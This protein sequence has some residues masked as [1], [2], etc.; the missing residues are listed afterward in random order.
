LE[1]TLRKRLHAS[2]DSVKTLHKV[3]DKTLAG[4]EQAAR[5][6]RAKQEARLAQVGLVGQRLG[7]HI[8][9]EGGVDVQLGEELSESLRGLQ[10]CAFFA[11]QFLVF[12]DAKGE[13]PRSI[14]AIATPDSP[15]EICSEIGF[16]ACN[17]A[18]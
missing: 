15:K 1:R 18:H 8:V 13:P 14:V 11:C 17:T 16:S 12:F 5:E 6:R 2:V 10:V 3:V 9:R 7:K 4:R